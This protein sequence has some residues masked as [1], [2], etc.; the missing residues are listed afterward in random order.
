MKDNFTHCKKLATIG[1]KMLIT[2]T[3]IS[4][5]NV[6]Q[7]SNIKITNVVEEAQKVTLINTL[8]KPSSVF[9]EASLPEAQLLTQA[10]VKD[11]QTLHLFSHGKPG[12]L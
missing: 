9:V 11:T 10:V 6:L 4:N 12:A 1:F 8:N 5:F 3:V 7:A 2:L